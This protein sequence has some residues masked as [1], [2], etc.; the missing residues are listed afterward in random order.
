MNTI[1]RGLAGGMTQSRPHLSRALSQGPFHGHY[2]SCCQSTCG[3][4]ELLITGVKS[5]PYCSAWVL[6]GGRSVEQAS[7][8]TSTVRRAFPGPMLMLPKQF[9]L[10]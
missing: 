1:F 4:P 3:S 8:A 5:K 6:A 9:W 10:S 2:C 7:S